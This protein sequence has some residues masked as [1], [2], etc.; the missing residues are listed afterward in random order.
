MGAMGRVR[1]G[2]GGR[3]LVRYEPLA[4][5]MEKVRES[6]CLLVRMFFAAGAREVSHGVH[7]PDPIFTDP[8]QVA[9]LQQGPLD[10]RRVHLLASHLFGT[11]C[12]GADPGRSVVDPALEC[13]ALKGLYVMDASVFPTNMG[14]NPQ[15]SIMALAWR[16]AAR[17]T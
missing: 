3:P 15:H 4:T 12:A 17:L 9:Q 10:P 8:A 13:H 11:A 1:P 14:V 6:L 2:W 7:G 16:A 5:D